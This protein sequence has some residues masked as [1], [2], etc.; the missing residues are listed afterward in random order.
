[1]EK[2]NREAIKI[3]IKANKEQVPMVD[4][5][6]EIIFPVYEAL[7]YSCEEYPKESDLVDR[8]KEEKEVLKIRLED[9]KA[10]CNVNYRT[11]EL[12][13]EREDK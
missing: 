3:L 1:M 2:S 11:L 9:L 6:S 13:L 8:L 5:I 12:V 7:I 10:H 4:L